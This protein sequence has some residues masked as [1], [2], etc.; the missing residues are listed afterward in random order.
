M[1]KSQGVERPTGVKSLRRG[2]D[3]QEDLLE[4]VVPVRRVDTASAQIRVHRCA[5]ACDKLRERIVVAVTG[6]PGLGIS[7]TSCILSHTREEGNG[8]RHAMKTPA[9]GPSIKSR[10]RD[11]RAFS[12]SA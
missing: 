5:V 4:Q 1:V 6:S 3:A 12:A 8:F 11:R 2:E 9:V 7:I 10:S